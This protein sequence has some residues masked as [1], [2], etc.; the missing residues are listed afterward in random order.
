MSSERA[1]PP[2][3]VSGAQHDAATDSCMKV[4]FGGPDRPRSAL[5]DL[6]I[7]RAEAVSAGGEILFATYYF[8]D[9]HLADALVRAHGRGVRLTICL[10]ASPRLSRANDA[11]RNRFAS[12][13]RDSFHPVS[14]LLPAHLHSKIYVFSH[15]A[16]TALVGSFNPSGDL[17]DDRRIIEAIGDQDRG[18]NYLVEFSDPVLVGFLRAQVLWLASGSHGLFERFDPAANVIGESR[19]TRVCFFP[20]RHSGV[21]FDILERQPYRHIRIA[22]SHFR[23]SGVAAALARLAA[24]GAKIEVI[25]HDTL[26]RVPERIAAFA[27]RSGITF[28]RYRHPLGWPMHNK[29]ILLESAAA[30]RL[31]FGSFNLTRTSRWLNHEVLVETDDALVYEAFEERWRHMLAELESFSDLARSRSDAMTDAIAGQTMAASQNLPRGP[32]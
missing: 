2:A 8:R 23:D 26:R 31:A 6:L 1:A 9:M 18:H 16:P 21:L 27:R 14:H 24:K 32:S 17:S 28:H 4:F 7:D 22:A 11:V 15:P 12:S 13:L 10:D 3:R 20:R 29:F 25:A 5:R 30:R 19:G